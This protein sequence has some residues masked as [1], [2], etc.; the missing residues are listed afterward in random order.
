MISIFSGKVHKKQ[1]VFALSSLILANYYQPLNV[2]LI[3]QKNLSST[4]VIIPSL[5]GDK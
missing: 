3:C 5:K 1:L 2:T 4:I